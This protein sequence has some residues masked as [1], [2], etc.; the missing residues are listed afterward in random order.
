MLPQS[1]R[2]RKI[3]D[4]MQHRLV[5]SLFS[6]SLLRE[7]NYKIIIKK[8]SITSSSAVSHVRSLRS[9]IRKASKISYSLYPLYSY[10]WQCKRNQRSVAIFGHFAKVIVRQYGYKMV[11]FGNEVLM[12]QLDHWSARMLRKLARL[13]DVNTVMYSLD[14]TQFISYPR[15]W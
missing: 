12:N 13:N 9:N 4:K 1:R 3:N 10:L 11:D 5:K 7:I 6:Q 2:T 8:P 14:P 15:I